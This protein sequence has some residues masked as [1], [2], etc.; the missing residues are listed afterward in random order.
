MILTEKLQKYQHY[1]QIKL[2]KMNIKQ[3]QEI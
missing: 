1:D 3:G 2:I